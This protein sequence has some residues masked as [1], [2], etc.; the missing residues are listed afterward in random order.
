MK[1]PEI[2]FKNWQSRLFLSSIARQQPILAGRFPSPIMGFLRWYERVVLRPDLAAY[3]VD[4]PIFVL[5]LPRSGTTMLQ[6]T[7]CRHPQIAYIN[8]TMN[9]FP[10][11]LCAVDHFRK[12]LGLDF[13]IERYLVDSVPVSPGGPSDALSFWSRWFD[14]DPYSLEYRDIQAKDLP[15][16]AR[17]AMHETIRKVIWCYGD[18]RMRFFNKVIQ[19]TTYVDM[20]RDLFPDARFVHIIRD[21]RM[22]ANSMVKL[23]KLEVQHQKEFGLYR[24]DPEQGEQFFIP[25]PRFPRLVEYIRTYGLTD[26]RTTAH[27]WQEVMDLVDDARERCPHFHEVRYEDLLEQPESEL[28]RILDFC[29]LAPVSRDNEYYWGKVRQ[30]GTIHH[31]RSYGEFGVVEEICRE[32][33]MRH[34]YRQSSAVPTGVRA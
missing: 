10:D 23:V 9:R 11:V 34:G 6:D 20:L 7:L 12:R 21:P 31:E 24:L 22:T 29:E 25:Y 33:M 19:C 26:L 14:V 2:Q 18:P 15:A 16:D 13:E 32:G 3:R 30:I 8:N 28:G 17:A 1:R 5:G 4:R 27:I